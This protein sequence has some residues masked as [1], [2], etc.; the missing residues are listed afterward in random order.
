MQPYSRQEL[1]SDIPG[2]RDPKTGA[3][4]LYMGGG[5]ASTDRLL[6]AR[7][8]AVPTGA[9]SVSGWSATSMGTIY[10]RGATN[11]LV[12]DIRGSLTPRR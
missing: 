7:P 5:T 8:M 9:S 1:T 4:I 6:T 11:P 12:D 2:R 10:L 3:V